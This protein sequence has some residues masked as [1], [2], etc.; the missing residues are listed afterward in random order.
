MHTTKIKTALVVA[1]FVMGIWAIGCNVD[2]RPSQFRTT[3]ASASLGGQASSDS[4]LA[5]ADESDLD[6]PEVDL[7][8]AVLTHRGLYRAR[9]DQ[10]REYYQRHGDLLKANWAAF[11]LK[12]LNSVRQFK[13]FLDAEIPSKELGA[14]EQDSGADAL[15]REGI[16][17]M[18]KGGHG[19][20]V[21]Y[22]EDR[23]VE[24]ANVFR[25][26]IDEYPSSDKIDDA[27]FHLGEIHEHYFPGQELL[28]ALWFERAATWDPETPYPARFRAA[29]LYD[30]HLHDRDHALE[31]YH[32]VVVQHGAETRNALRASKRIQQLTASPH[33]ISNGNLPA[34]I[35]NPSR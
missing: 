21:L 27:A 11:E 10:L 34:G 33:R 24:A 20:P 3:S 30:E 22:R 32:G 26:L 9:L 8:E 2:G 13:Y 17:L 4:W 28:A 19:V 31:L 1:T 7:V 25:Q 5:T 35:D 14:A 18:R 12:G 15:L 29:V 6:V 23:M 16:E